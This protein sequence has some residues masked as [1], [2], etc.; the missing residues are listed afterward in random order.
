MVIK[1]VVD[2]AEAAGWRDELQTYVTANP[3]AEG[4]PENDK[5]FFQL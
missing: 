2:D 3:T 1:N 4:F 5:Q